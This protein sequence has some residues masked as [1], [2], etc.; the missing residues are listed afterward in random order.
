MTENN[1]HPSLFVSFERSDCYGHLAACEFRIRCCKNKIF[2]GP[3][4]LSNRAAKIDASLYYRHSHF[5]FPSKK[6]NFLEELEELKLLVAEKN[7]ER[8]RPV[9]RPSPCR[10]KKVGKPPKMSSNRCNERLELEALV[11][12]E[13]GNHLV[14]EPS[15]NLA[16]TCFGETRTDRTCF[17]GNLK[18]KE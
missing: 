12:R 4:N 17:D 18:D 16:S 5:S 6:E 9:E 7:L 14:A 10:Y 1:R 11:G 3:R 13:I 2:R 8:K 15:S